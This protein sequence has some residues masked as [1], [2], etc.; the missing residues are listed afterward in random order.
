VE[1]IVNGSTFGGSTIKGGWIGIGLRLEMRI[2]SRI[3]STSPVQSF[4]VEPH[5]FEPASVFSSAVH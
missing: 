1:A 5:E 2:K 3:A 4:R